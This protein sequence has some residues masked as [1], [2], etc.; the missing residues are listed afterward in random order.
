[1]VGDVI[2]SLY[3]TSSPGWSAAV[4]LVLVD[5]PATPTPQTD[6]HGPWAMRLCCCPQLCVP[7]KTHQ[8]RTC[9]RAL[10]A[11]PLPHT[12]PH[13]LPYIQ[14]PGYTA[15]YNCIPSHHLRATPGKPSYGPWAQHHLTRGIHQFTSW[16]QLSKQNRNGSDRPVAA[17]PS[18]AQC[19]SLATPFPCFTLLLFA[20]TGRRL[21]GSPIQKQS[22]REMETPE[23][24][25]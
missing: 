8:T 10:P 12:H 17:S 21:M 7:H 18:D 3:S 13:I 23:C 24:Q 25:L 22:Q 1:M 14:V 4:T 15:P 5:K 16:L 2:E 19:S 11:S 6:G 20:A 9:P